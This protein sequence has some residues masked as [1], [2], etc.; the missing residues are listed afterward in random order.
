MLFIENEDLRKI[1]DKFPL[2]EKD[3]KLRDFVTEIE[4]FIEIEIDERED[5]K[6]EHENEINDL[7]EEIE[8]WEE[9]WENFEKE[10]DNECDRLRT[11]LTNMEDSFS[12]A[13]IER[14]KLKRE[15]S[16]YVERIIE[17]E[18]ERFQL[19]EQTKILK[20]IIQNFSEE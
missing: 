16:E 7:E 13:D 5:L 6:N 8:K 3:Q 9:K 1:V 15:N 14:D 19:Q 20:E 11:E 12:E 17:L 2:L 4:N 18:N 10:K